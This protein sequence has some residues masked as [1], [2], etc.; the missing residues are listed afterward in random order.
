LAFL[1]H[2]TWP[3]GQLLDGSISLKFSLETRKESEFFQPVVFNHSCSGAPLKMFWPAHV[4][5]LLE[6]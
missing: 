2:V 4:P 6:R 3:R 5:Y 1:I